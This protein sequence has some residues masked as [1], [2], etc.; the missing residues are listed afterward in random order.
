[1]SIASVPISL[2][3]RQ[4]AQILVHAKWDF[5]GITT[6]RLVFDSKATE[7]SPGIVLHVSQ[8]TS[9]AEALARVLVG[10]FGTANVHIFALQFSCWHSS[11]RPVHQRIKSKS[12]SGPNRSPRFAFPSLLRNHL[13]TTL[14]MSAP[15]RERAHRISRKDHTM[16]KGRSWI[17]RKDK[18]IGLGNLRVPVISIHPLRLPSRYMPIQCAGGTEE[19]PGRS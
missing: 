17:F 2:Y 15:S 8:V 18:T 7:Y 1:M 14:A 19:L 9:P 11:Q 5:H 3:P 16:L 12:K 4:L 10:I 6:P 13:R